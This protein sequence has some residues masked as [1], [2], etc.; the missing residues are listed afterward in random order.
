MLHVRLFGGFEAREGD[1]VLPFAESVR[2]QAL[3]AALVACHFLRGG[4]I[5][6]HPGNA[7][8]VWHFLRSLSDDDIAEPSPAKRCDMLRE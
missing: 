1:A 2:A 7:K 3:L 6:P 8:P 5:C 4:F